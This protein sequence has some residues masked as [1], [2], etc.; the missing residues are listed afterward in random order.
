[1]RGFIEEI[2]RKLMALHIARGE[3]DQEHENDTDHGRD[4][5]QPATVTS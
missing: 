3:R 2:E 5:P 4:D 1:V